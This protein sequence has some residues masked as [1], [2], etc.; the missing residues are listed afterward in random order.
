MNGVLYNAT[1]GIA[2]GSAEISST[3]TNYSTNPSFE[4]ATTGVSTGGTA[5][6]LTTSTTQARFGTQSLQ[7]AW[8]TA[9]SQASRLSTTV[10]GLS[11]NT[12]YTVSLYVYVP[13]GS[14]F[15]YMSL[16]G[17]T[18]ASPYTQTSQTGQWQRLTLTATTLNTRTLMAFKLSRAQ[19]LHRISM[20]HLVQ[21]MLGRVQ[22]T[23]QPQ[24]EQPAH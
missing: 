7:I 13:A 21:A 10:S 6:T 8:P 20:A 12:T 1:A 18:T 24:P 2:S 4:T 17:N 23:P 16:S 19:L 3:T 14:P 15:V 9:T 5:P 22:L 11:A